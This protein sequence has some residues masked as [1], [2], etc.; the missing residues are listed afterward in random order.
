[1]LILHQL[2]SNTL[3]FICNAKQTNKKYFLKQYHQKSWSSMFERKLYQY[4][5]F[6]SFTTTPP[7]I[8]R[9]TNTG[10]NIFSIVKFTEVFTK[11]LWSSFGVSKCKMCDV[12]L[13]LRPLKDKRDSYFWSS[14][15]CS[16]GFSK[17]N[18]RSKS[19]LQKWIIFYTNAI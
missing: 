13:K 2:V 19:A 4:E 18:D 11:N 15:K 5:L 3:I 6:V 17:M 9:A 12:G 10:E 1:M 14:L 7:V 8:T 16:K